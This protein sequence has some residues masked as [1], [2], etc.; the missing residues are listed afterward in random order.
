M[1][2]CW[3]FILQVKCH[4]RGKSHSY[5]QPLCVLTGLSS[6]APSFCTWWTSPTVDAEADGLHRQPEGTGRGRDQ[7]SGV[8]GAFCLSSQRWGD[9]QRLTALQGLQEEL[10]LPR[11]RGHSPLSG[12]RGILVLARGLSKDCA[13]TATSTRASWWIPDFSSLACLSPFPTC[14]FLSDIQTS[15]SLQRDPTCLQ[16]AGSQLLPADGILRK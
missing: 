9:P 12:Y 16:Q 10:S 14:L 1:F 8:L 4:L 2:G 7:N 11:D 3:Q 5:W 15:L 6:L 13:C